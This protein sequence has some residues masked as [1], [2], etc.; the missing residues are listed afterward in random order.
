MAD[1]ASYR[2]APGTI[3]T[4]PGVYRFRDLEGRVLYVGKAKSLRARLSNYFQDEY[5]LSP[6]IRQMVH[7]A[8]RVEWV[9]VGSE[10]EALTLE[11]S[12][13]KE[14]EPRF[15]V[16]FRDNKS[17]PYL[18]VSLSEEF[19]RVWITRQKHRSGVRY[20]GPYTKVWAIRETLD[21]LLTAFPMRSCTKGQFNQ[22][23]RAGRPCLYGYI[24][25]C[26]AP[27]VG[28]VS[29]DEHREIALGLTDFMDGDSSK[30]IGQRK[31]EMMAAAAEENFERAARLRDQ[32]QALEAASERNVVVF[33]QNLDAD[34][35]GLEY[36]DLEASVQVFFVRGGR[37]RGQR[38]WVSEEIGGLGAEEIVG[39]LM[40]QV[41]G[42]PEYDELPSLRAD[43]TSIDDRKHTPVGA[44]PAEIW[45]PALPEDQAGIEE[46]LRS[47]RGDRPVRLK[48]PQRGNKAKLAETV[49]ENAAQALQ[50]HKLARAADITV[51]SQALEEL[52]EGLGL[53]RAPLRIECYDISHT[54]GQHQVASMVVFEDGLSKKADYRHFIVRGPEGKGVPDDTAAMDEVLRRRLSRLVAGAAADDAGA[55]EDEAKEDELS[56]SGDVQGKPRRFAYRPDLLVVDGGLPQVNAAQRVVDELGAQLQVVGLA[57]RLEEVWIPGDDFPVIFPRTSPALRLLQQLRDESHRFAITFH[58]KKRGKAM[59]R[60]ALDDI[61]GLGPAKQKELL[62]AFGSVAK[63]RGASAGELQAVKGIGPR[64]A[65]T[66]VEAL[67]NS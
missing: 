64:L 58:R 40:L 57:K 60:S 55:A 1:P 13:I 35:F 8:S 52:R 15:N 27:C 61:P 63:I 24:G 20:F 5:S 54:Q 19:P 25:R 3:P 45:V 49:H 33:E 26:S 62:K 7:T 11:Y 30:V 44:I 29:S 22:A 32:V 17:Y 59:T 2:P 47:R 4:R 65:A 23:E 16:V 43:S 66:I 14:F 56:G 46:W 9:I 41:Y 36:D 28:R 18:A 39:E 34:I 42:D 37:I 51:R 48:V 67:A 12:W 21:E 31:K 10:V 53:E 50:R 38:G 6:R